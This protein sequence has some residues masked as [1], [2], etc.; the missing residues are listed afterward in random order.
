MEFPQLSAAV[1]AEKTPADARQQVPAYGPGPSLRPQT[2][3][4]W[5]RGTTGQNAGSGVNGHPDG[6][7]P[8]G[9]RGQPNRPGFG[10]QE[11][12]GAQKARYDPR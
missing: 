11:F 3:G 5:I 8:R 6:A 1:A 4:S 9:Q 12:N 10:S 7:G 2:E